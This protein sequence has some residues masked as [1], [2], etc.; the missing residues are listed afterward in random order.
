MVLDGSEYVVSHDAITPSVSVF[1]QGSME[2]I[3]MVRETGQPQAF[4]VCAQLLSHV[5]L[6]V[7]PST[8]AFQA[9]LSIEFSRQGYWSG[10]S[11]PSPGDLP[12]PE[13]EPRSPALAGRFFTT[14]PPEKLPKPSGLHQPRTID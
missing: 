5:E 12:D 8:V 9:R 7:T 11:F 1:Q 3:A 10:L 13:S 2:I 6:F 14:E 4:C